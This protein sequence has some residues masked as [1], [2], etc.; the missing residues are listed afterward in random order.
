MK[1]YILD[2]FSQPDSTVRVVICTV[3]FGLGV[4]TPDVHM[5]LH[6]GA[7]RTFEGFFQEYGRA[8][9]DPMAVPQAFSV[10]YYHAADISTS[11]TVPR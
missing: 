5:V 6:W 3:A 10:V 8:R 9:R 2:T 11:A 1:K 7:A 4:D